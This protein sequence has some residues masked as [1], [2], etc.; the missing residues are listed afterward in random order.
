MSIPSIPYCHV[1]TVVIYIKTNIRLLPMEYCHSQ[2]NNGP[3]G[4]WAQGALSVRTTLECSLFVTM[5]HWFTYWYCQPWV[6]LWVDGGINTHKNEPHSSAQQNKKN[7]CWGIIPHKHRNDAAK[8][9]GGGQKKYGVSFVPFMFSLEKPAISLA[10]LALQSPTLFLSPLV[11]FQTPRLY[12]VRPPR[13]G[14][15]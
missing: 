14:C 10:L 8:K 2:P 1:C 11:C 5:F 15:I 7:Q 6:V 9:K 13:I 12:T 3:C 4:A